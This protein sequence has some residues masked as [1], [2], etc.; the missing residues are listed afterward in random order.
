MSYCR[1]T[2]DLSDDLSSL[3]KSVTCSYLVALQKLARHLVIHPEMLIVLALQLI[4]FNEYIS[5]INKY[6]NSTTVLHELQIMASGLDANTISHMMPEHE[7]SVILH[8]VVEV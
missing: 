6:N 2:T 4:G 7:W 3:W 1:L 8:H 5:T